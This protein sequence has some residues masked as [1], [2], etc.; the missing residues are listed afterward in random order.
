MELVEDMFV[1][2]FP[3]V[4]EEGLKKVSKAMREC[5]GGAPGVYLPEN[6][7]DRVIDCVTEFMNEF[8]S[9]QYPS[10]RHDLLG[11]RKVHGNASLE[12]FRRRLMRSPGC[13]AQSRRMSPEN[14]QGSELHDTLRPRVPAARMSVKV[15]NQSGGLG[16]PCPCQSWR[17][18]PQIQSLGRRSSGCQMTG[19]RAGRK[20]PSL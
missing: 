12:E 17:H 1:G 8:P 4:L 19:L 9:S 7:S 20:R 14:A 6:L 13:E 11:P 15:P 5:S 16:A 3:A 2:I 18:I 10:V